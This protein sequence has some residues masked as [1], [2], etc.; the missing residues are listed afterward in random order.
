[1]PWVSIPRWPAVATAALTVDLRDILNFDLCETIPMRVEIGRS[2]AIRDTVFGT[3]PGA[4]EPIR[5]V[6]IVPLA[7]SPSDRL[8]ESP[9]FQR[10][11]GL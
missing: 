4:P 6:G 10:L 7:K 8:F 1:M 9:E 3:I 2:G 11:M 5:F